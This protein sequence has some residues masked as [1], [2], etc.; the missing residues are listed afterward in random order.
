MENYNLDFRNWG[1]KE[2]MRK[3]REM[4]TPRSS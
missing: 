4:E 3:Q 2:M 1:E